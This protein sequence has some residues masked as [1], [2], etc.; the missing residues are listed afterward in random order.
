MAPATY[1]E[2]FHTKIETA[3]LLV[4]PPFS[5][6]KV[7]ANVTIKIPTNVVKPS[8]PSFLLFA[9]I[10]SRCSSAMF[11]KPLPSTFTLRLIEQPQRP[12]CPVLNVPIA[13]A[14]TRDTGP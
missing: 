3:C 11:L 6:I 5:T 12:C 1:P 9:F 14:N 2:I 8:I 4:K 13:A 10:Q 7:I